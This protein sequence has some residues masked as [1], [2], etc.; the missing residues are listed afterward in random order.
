MR[1]RTC[2]HARV[3]AVR[4]PDAPIRPHSGAPLVAPAAHAADER[5]L[6]LLVEECAKG[7][8]SVISVDPEGSM[9]VQSEVDARCVTGQRQLL[10]L[11]LRPGHAQQRRA[12]L[13]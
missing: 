7:E 12:A 6:R 8:E 5:M 10:L 1:T 2:T 9:L 4:V 3:H 11:L 13:T